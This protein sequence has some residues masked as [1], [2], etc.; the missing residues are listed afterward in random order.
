MSAGTLKSRDPDVNI[1][2]VVAGGV[3]CALIESGVKLAASTT[4]VGRIDFRK[5]IIGVPFFFGDAQPGWFLQANENAT[6]HRD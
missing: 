2:R 1:G 6:A 3:A 5:L 4:A